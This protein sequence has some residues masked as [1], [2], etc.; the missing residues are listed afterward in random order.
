MVIGLTVVLGDTH[1]IEGLA[2]ARLIANAVA[3][4]P[5]APRVL[6]I[7][8]SGKALVEPDVQPAGS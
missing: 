1:G 3:G 6:R 5:A 8:R 7:L 4:C 2:V